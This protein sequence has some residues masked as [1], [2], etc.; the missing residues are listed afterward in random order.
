M[1]LAIETFIRILMLV[2]LALTIIILFY[3]Y[4]IS[5]EFKSTPGELV[6]IHNK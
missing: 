1:E 3:H 2:T 5:G 4:K 6:L